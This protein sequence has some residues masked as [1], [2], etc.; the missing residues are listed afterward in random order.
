MTARS[1]LETNDGSQR[2]GDIDDL[3][4]LPVELLAGP[5]AFRRMLSRMG[6][7]LLDGDR[8]SGAITPVGIRIR[9]LPSRMLK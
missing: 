5:Q 4:S 7:G 1:I 2:A 8:Q 9:S 3:E 6:L